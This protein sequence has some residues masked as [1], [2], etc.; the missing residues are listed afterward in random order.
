MNVKMKVA[1]K[2][3][4]KITLTSKIGEGLEGH[5]VEVSIRGKAVAKFLASEK[6]EFLNVTI[7]SRNADPEELEP[8]E[9]EDED[10][11]EDDDE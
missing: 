11:D 2:G 4:D 1:H 3:K 9:D 5:D 8:E 7:S 10:D 6:T